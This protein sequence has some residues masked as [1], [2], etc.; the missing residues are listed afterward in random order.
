MNKKIKELKILVIGCGSI[1]ERHLHNLRYLGMK[2]IAISDINKKK[3]SELSS[4]YKI[5]K[6]DDI[7]SALEFEPD[8]SLICTHPNSHASIAKACIEMN[9]HVFI[10]KPISINEQGIEKILQRAKIKQ[11]KIAVGYNNRFEK[12][13]KVVKKKITES[14]IGQPHAISVQF[15]NNIKFWRPGTDFKNHYILKKGGGIV[16]DDSHEYD[17]VR[18]LLNDE[19]YSVYAQTQKMTSI[20]TETE[21]IAAFILKF[22]KGVIASFMIDYVRPQYERSC[23]IIGEKGDIKWQYQP[24]KSSWKNYNSSSMSKVITNHINKKRKIRNF[25][26]K[27]NDMYVEEIQDFLNSVIMNTEP[28]VN[29]WEGLKTL[30]IGRAI[31]KSAKENKVILV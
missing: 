29:G 27:S 19:V 1:G 6:F 17:Y 22:K 13:L 3:I 20:K 11:L 14:E 21:S 15:G 4:K 28:T 18:W 30:Q 23:Q 7:N 5:K 2:K 8:V 24:Q 25:R 31:L 26:S 16:L 10:E 9:S 12:G